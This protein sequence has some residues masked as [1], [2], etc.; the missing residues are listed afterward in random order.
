MA[1][2]KVVQINNDDARLVS[3]ATTGIMFRNVKCT[4]FI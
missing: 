2:F 4:S 1:Q 3:K